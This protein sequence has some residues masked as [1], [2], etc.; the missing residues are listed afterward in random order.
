MSSTSLG[1]MP[2]LRASLR[3]GR[4]ATSRLNRTRSQ[5]VLAGSSPA[6][7]QG[8]SGAGAGRAGSGQA[9]D[10][11]LW[12]SRGRPQ[13]AAFAEI[14]HA[15]GNDRPVPHPPGS[16]APVFRCRGGTRTVLGRTAVPVHPATPL[17]GPRGGFRSGWPTARP[18]TP[19]ARGCSLGTPTPDGDLVPPP[20]LAGESR[21]APPS[22]V[23]CPGLSAF[24]QVGPAGCSPMLGPRLSAPLSAFVRE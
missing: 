17:T 19:A 22:P 6:P 1:G 21:S 16:P 5:L 14:S 4:V 7:S 20:G 18:A 11:V 15:G 12:V 10:I 13:D 3:I 9:S 2:L 24:G 8:G 23:R